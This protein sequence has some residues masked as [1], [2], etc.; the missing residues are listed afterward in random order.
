MV[1]D[2][3][4][5]SSLPA[6]LE[7]DRAQ[8]VADLAAENHFVPLTVKP[9]SRCADRSCCISPCSD[10]RLVFDIRRGN[11]TRLAMIGLALGPFRRL[12]KDYQLLVDSHIKAVEEGRA[13]RI[14]AI[15]MGRR[16]LHNEGATLMRAA[17]RRQDRHRLRHGAAAVHAGLRAAPEGLR[18]MRI[19]GVPYRTI[20]VD[21]DD[22]WSVRII[23]QTKLPWALEIVRL[24]D[25][26]QAAHAIRSMQVRGAPLIGAAAAYGLCLGAAAGSVVGGAG[27]R[28]GAAGGDAADRDQSALGAR[29]DADPAAQHA[30]RRARA[31]RLCGSRRDRRRGRGAERG[32]RPAR[33]AADRAGG[34]AGPAR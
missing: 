17:A 19:D 11:G 28:R 34:A 5:P 27:A 30:G 33:A 2:G 26:A 9:G 25:V 24:T 23:D 8:A 29:A 3:E 20:W 16:G 10:G 7:A 1:L 4:I 21:P 22:G 14:Q 12:V 15:D 18:L 32:D 13:E 31:R 6:A